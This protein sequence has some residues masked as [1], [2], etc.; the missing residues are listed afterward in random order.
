MRFIT[1]TLPVT[2]P[3]ICITIVN[4]VYKHKLSDGQNLRGTS[5]DTL[6]R[7]GSAVVA[8]EPEL[9]A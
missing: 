2:L 6:F 3:V 7:A 4:H 9:E 5:T 1:S 8:S